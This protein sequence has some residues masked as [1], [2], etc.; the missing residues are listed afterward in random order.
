MN[1]KLNVL[2]SNKFNLITGHSNIRTTFDGWNNRIGSIHVYEYGSLDASNYPQILDDY[3]IKT[4][5]EPFEYMSREI[6][7]N[8]KHFYMFML[9]V[10]HL[11]VFYTIIYY[12]KVKHYLNYHP[13]NIIVR[14]VHTTASMG[15]ST[16]K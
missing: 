14:V 12:K 10:K 11:C 2:D 15:I 3:N 13:C 4:E 6:S 9:I 7:S 8:T 5:P 1:E 16:E